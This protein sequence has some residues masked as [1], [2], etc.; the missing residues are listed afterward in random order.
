MRLA[1]RESAYCISHTGSFLQN[2][3]DMKP[4]YL[5]SKL[6][7]YFKYPTR[8]WIHMKNGVYDTNLKI[9]RTKDA[10][11]CICQVLGGELPTYEISYQLK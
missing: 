11:F 4:V 10:N 9:G 3:K 5:H 8:T 6:T 1:K 7:S 2:V